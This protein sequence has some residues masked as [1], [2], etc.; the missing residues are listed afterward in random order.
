V[1]DEALIH[2]VEVGLATNDDLKRAVT[3]R[4]LRKV[5]VAADSEDE[6]VRIAIAMTWRGDLMVTHAHYVL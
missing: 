1:D 4:E 5:L 2:E 6:A 3:T